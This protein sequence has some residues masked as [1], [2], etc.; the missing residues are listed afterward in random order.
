M[1][2]SRSNWRSA[3]SVG[4]AASLPSKIFR[5]L[6]ACATGGFA[7]RACQAGCAHVLD[8]SHGIMREQFQTSFE[9]QFFLER[10]ANLHGW[11]IFAR[12]LSQFA[13]SERGAS[14]TVA[15]GFGADI[16]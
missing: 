1:V 4:Q 8:S 16:K 14:K 10:I 3:S 15:S 12:L 5:K 2:G 7:G 11:T 6:E 13:R 9:Q